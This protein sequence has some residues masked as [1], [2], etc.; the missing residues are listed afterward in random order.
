MNIDSD[1]PEIVGRYQKSSSLFSELHVP[2]PLDNHKVNAHTGSNLELPKRMDSMSLQ[3][4]TNGQKLV[5]QLP[6][7]K[8]SFELPTPSL[9]EPSADSS[10]EALIEEYKS[11]LRKTNSV[12]SKKAS[13]LIVKIKSQSANDH[14]YLQNLLVEGSKTFVNDSSESAVISLK[15]WEEAYHVANKHQDYIHM[16]FAMNNV[17]LV[18]K[19]KNDHQKALVSS[20]HAWKM[21]LK[22][23]KFA[24]NTPKET[25][26]I[27]SRSNSSSS[28]S[29]SNI[30]STQQPKDS[31]KLSKSVGIPTVVGMMDISLNRGNIYYDL[32]QYLDAIDHYESCLTTCMDALEIWPLPNT[33]KFAFDKDPIKSRV[34]AK[35]SRFHAHILETRMKALSSIGCSYWKIGDISGSSEYINRSLASL[36]IYE[37]MSLK[38]VTAEISAQV[39]GN[40]AIQMH[41]VL[42]FREAILINAMALS[43]FDQQ[44]S[45][46]GLVKSLVNHGALLGEFAKTY[47]HC[48]RA[49]N[50]AQY[51]RTSLRCVSESMPSI[52]LTFDAF[53]QELSI[54]VVVCPIL[55]L[56]NKEDVN[57]ISML[58]FNAVALEASMNDSTSLFYSTVDRSECLLNRAIQLSSQTNS[59][60]FAKLNL[61][62]IPV[63]S[64]NFSFHQIAIL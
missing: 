50:H 27:L 23:M 52:H 46:S 1:F 26:K 21:I 51:I 48:N 4:E 33:L 25:L 18:H 19:R 40:F 30:C 56:I 32:G 35:L 55:R 44:V 13:D 29:E 12:T 61:G 6:S 39:F 57:K 9:I 24:N 34:K 47:K 49:Y 59:T 20:D 16:A 37:K 36:Y 41:S 31:M 53:E 17:S 28:N 5:N 43:K 64:P 3:E 38:K 62:I 8:T 11:C 42:K 2:F 60:N 7:I 63:F 10:C 45:K 54:F 58:D 14:I 15:M 22:A